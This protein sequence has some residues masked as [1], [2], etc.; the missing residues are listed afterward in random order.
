MQVSAVESEQKIDRK[1]LW[2]TSKCGKGP[3]PRFHCASRIRLHDL[4]ALV[5][6]ASDGK[7]VEEGLSGVGIN[8]RCMRICIW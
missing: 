8:G 7:F 1:R 2:R 4:A 6:M 5:Q 3:R